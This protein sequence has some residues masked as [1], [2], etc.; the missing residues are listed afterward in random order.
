[1]NI[2]KKITRKQIEF[3][4]Y[5]NRDASCVYLGDDE[6]C[7]LLNELN[8]LSRYSFA[9]INKDSNNK[10]KGMKIYHVKEKSHLNLA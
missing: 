1:M 10:F 9:Y 7:L 2:I 6:Y 5:N 4:K 8:Y 3:Y